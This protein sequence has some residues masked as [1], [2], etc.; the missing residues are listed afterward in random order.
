MFIS[1]YIGI[2]L[3]TCI[4]ISIPYSFAPRWHWWLPMDI[5][6]PPPPQ[7]SFSFSYS[8]PFDLLLNIGIYKRSP[9]LP[10]SPI[11]FSFLVV[12]PISLL[13]WGIYQWLIERFLETN[14]KAYNSMPE[15]DFNLYELTLWASQPHESLL[16]HHTQSQ[17]WHWRLST[18]CRKGHFLFTSILRHT[19]NRSKQLG[20]EM[21]WLVF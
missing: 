4:Y 18:H 20:N 12:F 2:I 15:P 21:K 3:A 6:R 17:Q 8:F 9:L 19:R 7:T 16:V 13:N 1:A 14:Y 10:H 5:A 11:I